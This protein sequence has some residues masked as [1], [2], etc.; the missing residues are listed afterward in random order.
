MQRRVF[1]RLDPRLAL[2]TT[3]VLKAADIIFRN[4]ELSVHTFG[5]AGRGETEPP[6]G[7]P[8]LYRNRPVSEQVS[9]GPACGLWQ[10]L[11]V[12]AAVAAAAIA[13]VSPHRA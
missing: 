12:A 2:H 3:T 6:K 11:L 13:A 9:P 7:D 5:T 10:R 8:A 1:I 4:S